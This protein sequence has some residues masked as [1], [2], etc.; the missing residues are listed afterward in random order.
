M[1]VR[2]NLRAA[3]VERPIG[4][5]IQVSNVTTKLYSLIVAAPAHTRHRNHFVISCGYTAAGRRAL[6]IHGGMARVSLMIAGR[7][8]GGSRKKKSSWSIRVVVNRW[9]QTDVRTKGKKHVIYSNGDA[10]KG[11]KKY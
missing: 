6:G 8:K 2:H 5:G 3:R 7:E 10:E 4:T 1:R 11:E 9:S